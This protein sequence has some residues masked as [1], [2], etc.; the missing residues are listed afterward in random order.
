MS[1]DWNL[2]SESIAVPVWGLDAGEYNYTI[3]VSDF[4]G[5]TAVDTVMVAVQPPDIFAGPT[6]Y[7]LIAGVIV[8]LVVVAVAYRK[9]LSR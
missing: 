8:L 3:E 7:I 4:A 5:N 1:G 6:P 9:L 2:S